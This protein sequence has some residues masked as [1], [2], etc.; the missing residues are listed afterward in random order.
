MGDDGKQKR[1]GGK[2]RRRTKHRTIRFSGDENAPMGK[3]M[4]ATR[5]SPGSSRLHDA[6]PNISLPR[7]GQPAINH[8]KMVACLAA[9]AKFA[10]AIEADRAELGKSASNLNQITRILNAGTDPSRNMDILESALEQHRAA[11]A[12]AHETLD[13]LKE[14]HTMTMQVLGYEN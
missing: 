6:L 7:H 14:L 1:R 12:K 9:A 3:L 2:S 5:Q 4:E 13:E 8:E 10:D 11:L